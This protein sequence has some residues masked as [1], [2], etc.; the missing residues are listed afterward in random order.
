MSKQ[1]KY[2][3]FLHS[4]SRMGAGTETEFCNEND[5]KKFSLYAEYIDVYP[6]G[7]KLSREEKEKLGMQFSP[8]RK[9]TSV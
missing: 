5:L 8:S 6:V 1:Q 7:D 2:I 4:D 3:V 9:R